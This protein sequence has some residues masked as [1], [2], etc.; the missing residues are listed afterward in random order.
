MLTIGLLLLIGTSAT[1]AD[2]LDALVERF[3]RK[4]PDAPS[5]E[6]RESSFKESAAA[7][8][9]EL[10]ERGSRTVPALRRGLKHYFPIVRQM[11][12]E[13]LVELGARASDLRPA[14]E[15]PDPALRYSA[16]KHFIDLKMKEGIDAVVSCLRLTSDG[17]R[18][19]VYAAFL[20]HVTGRETDF[21]WEG[22]TAKKADA[23]VRAWEE[24][25]AKKRRGYEFPRYAAVYVDLE[26][27]AL[28]EEVEE[29]DPEELAKLEK[30]ARDPSRKAEVMQGIEA[31][32]EGTESLVPEQILECASCLN[33]V[34]AHERALELCRRLTDEANR[35]RGVSFDIYNEQAHFETAVALKGLGKIDGARA[36]I[37]RARILKPDDEKFEA[38]ERGLKSG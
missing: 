11:S 14:L 17:G 3:A 37:H 8:Q 31:L 23:E 5:T 36:A 16:G 2:D 7:V 4:P 1:G 35:D 10:M 25:W 29:L 22:A 30:A 20:R 34:G 13:T 6:F 33:R 26:P 28:L 32:L 21:D 15:D 24:W 18:R 27:M 38:F 9:A 12:F 19:S